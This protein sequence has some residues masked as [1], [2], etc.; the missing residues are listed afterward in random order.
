VNPSAH[1][2]SERHLVKGRSQRVSKLE[3]KL[4]QAKA[5]NHPAN[6][7]I[8]HP[9]E[10]ALAQALAHAL[11]SLSLYPT[12]LKKYSEFLQHNLKQQGSEKL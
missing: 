6:L 8:Q 12:K 10:R 7:C 9:T 1:Q 11:A 4:D 5:P 2:P 3:N